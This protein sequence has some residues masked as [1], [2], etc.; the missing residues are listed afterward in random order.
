MLSPSRQAAPP[1]ESRNESRPATRRAC[2]SA[3]GNHERVKQTSNGPI[4][5]SWTPYAGRAPGSPDKPQRLL[6]DEIEWFVDADERNL[7]EADTG[8]ILS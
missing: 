7:S 4:Q 2:S 1:R 6:M 5:A 8:P 3:T